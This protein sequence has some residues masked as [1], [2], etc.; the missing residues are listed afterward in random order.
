METGYPNAND[1]GEGRDRVFSRSL[2]GHSRIEFA[3][4]A[5][6]RVL[7]T[8]CKK[9]L[10]RLTRLW[11]K[12]LGW[13]NAGRIYPGFPWVFWSVCR[14]EAL[15]NVTNVGVGVSNNLDLD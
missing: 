4:V 3:P 13:K 5:A 9:N 15:R 12:A 6:G 10:G 1:F 14:S 2:F 8:T 11:L 7:R